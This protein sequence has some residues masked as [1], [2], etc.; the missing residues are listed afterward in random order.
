MMKKTLLTALM[1]IIFISPALADYV[2][3]TGDSLFVRD[4]SFE[5]LSTPG[6]YLAHIIVD[7][8]YK[9]YANPLTRYQSV[10]R[11]RWNNWWIPPDQG[12][13][14]W[15]RF[16]IGTI[17][18]SFNISNGELYNNLFLDYYYEIG[19]SPQEYCRVREG[20]EICDPAPTNP[21]Q[22]GYYGLP[23]YIQAI[24][25]FCDVNNKKKGYYYMI[26]THDWEDQYDLTRP[27][28]QG[29]PGPD[30]F[31]DSEIGAIPLGFSVFGKIVRTKP[32][33]VKL[34][35]H[36][37]TTANAELNVLLRP[38]RYYRHTNPVTSGSDTWSYSDIINLGTELTNKADVNLR[39][40]IKFNYTGNWWNL[41]LSDEEVD[42]DNAII[43]GDS[44]SN[45]MDCEIDF[46]NL[47]R[48]IYE[49][50]E[51]IS[52]FKA[53]LKD[54]LSLNYDA[55]LPNLPSLT[56]LVNV[57]SNIKFSELPE[58]LKS[59]INT[60]NGVTCQN[61]PNPHDGG[62]LIDQSGNG[63]DTLSAIALF[64]QQDV[65]F[66]LDQLDKKL[67]TKKFMAKTVIPFFTFIII[68]V[69][70]MFEIMALGFALFALIPMMFRNF[71][72]GIK[73]SFDLS[74]LQ[75]IK[76]GK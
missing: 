62:D 70:Y 8:G 29:I 12:G 9:N 59:T 2:V 19:G 45:D 49:T 38:N 64:R 20:V 73:E 5:K 63:A 10:L 44:D 60:G 6:D 46:S 21:Q 35:T 33:T 41:T 14:D 75:K 25:F 23:F 48:S 3:T 30:V 32:L 61:T 53:I 50:H 42:N 11:Y 26:P 27:S 31:V 71:L 52:F 37:D 22:Q 43:S 76:R 4:V 57:K 69:F 67:E 51:Y 16:G 68:L 1:I 13:I 7:L 47:E 66:Q 56:G 58:D 39:M 18:A 24:E 40:N 72:K 65:A 34:C 54:V 15:A 28:Y 55:T 74:E 17:G 36:M